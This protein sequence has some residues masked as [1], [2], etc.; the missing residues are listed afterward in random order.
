MANFSID[1]YIPSSPVEQWTNWVRRDIEREFNPD[2][3]DPLML[4]QIS[5]V[6]AQ[7][8]RD[9]LARCSELSIKHQQYLNEIGD[10]RASAALSAIASLGD[11]ITATAKTVTS[12]L[13]DG[14]SAMNY[15]LSSLE[16]KTR[17]SNQIM[18]GISHGIAET[19][20]QI[21]A[22]TS[23]V[24]RM[25][26]SL[27]MGFSRLI[28]RQEIIN[29]NLKAISS[30]I[31]RGIDAIKIAIDSTCAGIYAIYSEL[32]NPEFVRQ[33]RWHA[34]QGTKFLRL[35]IEKKDLSYYDDA[36]ESFDELIKIDSKDS[37][38]W[39]YLGYLYLYSPHHINISKAETAFDKYL[40]YAESEKSVL[41][42]WE[43]ACR[44]KANCRYLA[45]DVKDAVATLNKIEKPSLKTL[46]LYVK[47]LSASEETKK[48]AVNYARQMFEQNPFA[49]MMLLQD[50]DVMRN[51][52]I[53]IFL[54]RLNES[55]KEKA[56]KLLAETKQKYDAL[57]AEIKKEIENF[58]KARDDVPSTL[59]VPNIQHLTDSITN[60]TNMIARHTILEHV[61]AM[62]LCRNILTEI[63]SVRENFL[64]LV[65]H[66]TNA[67]SYALSNPVHRLV[68]RDKFVK[69]TESA[70]SATLPQM[71]AFE[72]I[73][74]AWDF[75]QKHTS[76]VLNAP[77]EVGYVSC[78]VGGQ[79]INEYLG[80]DTILSVKDK[81]T[82]EHT[83]NAKA[84]DGFRK[85]LASIQ[86]DI[87]SIKQ[88]IAS[89][90]K[91]Y[92]KFRLR[93]Y[94]NV[95]TL[96]TTLSERLGCLTF[97]LV[98]D[99]E[100]RAYFCAVAKLTV[101]VPPFPGSFFKL[102]EKSKW[103]NESSR[104]CGTN[105]GL[106]NLAQTVSVKLSKY[107][108]RLSPQ[109]RKMAYKWPN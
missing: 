86:H 16:E 43:E 97:P 71:E 55:E 92:R 24:H 40:H 26:D 77:L 29:G 9:T 49:I 14:F 34:E 46:E 1:R 48:S 15:S 63:K 27:N 18:Q 57:C 99:K 109:Y 8:L 70:V 52:E 78:T 50:E 74:K 32:R 5:V 81:A 47:F 37:V 54:R 19:N 76:S 41:Y 79:T 100:I 44:Y 3:E 13:E 95:G 22:M 53:V 84:I 68:A 93:N 33:T 65:Q 38:G 2:L 56:Q 67:L 36:Y 64:S 10:K 23:G 88:A 73:M 62:D 85:R 102:G 35:A 94:E 90:R 80:T 21:S 17:I 103:K 51:E 82:K 66:A 60:A 30:Q 75:F 31:D 83:A 11:N 12:S 72:N 105:A 59:E 28:S 98:S 42:L 89:A 25:A 104:I 87:D 107:L 4:Q 108:K 91:D 6:Q 20:M 61:S 69:G 45:S 106:R 58:D 7:D 96:A 39:F 101:E